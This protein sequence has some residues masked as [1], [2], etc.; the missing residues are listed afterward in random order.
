MSSRNLS[1]RYLAALALALTIG[2]AAPAFPQA[3]E[4]S[5]RPAAAV[6]RDQ[7]LQGAIDDTPAGRQ[8]LGTW[9]EQT[10]SGPKAVAAQAVALIRALRTAG[11]NDPGLLQQTA[12]R[13]AQSAEKILQQVHIYRASVAA[14]L[15]LGAGHIGFV[16]QSPDAVAPPGFEVILPRDAR[17]RGANMR[18]IRSPVAAPILQ[19]GIVGVRSVTLKVANGNYRL[20]LLTADMQVANLNR[21]P[22]GTTVRVNERS[23]TVAAATPREWLQKAVLGGGGGIGEGGALVLT[24]AVTDGTLIVSFLDPVGETFISGL[25]L[26]PL[27]QRSALNGVA[28]DGA[29]ENVATADA[30]IEDTVGSLLSEI[31]TAAGPQ[32]NNLGL[33][34]PPAPAPDSLSAN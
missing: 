23:Y 12:D 29:D 25:V 33:N 32:Q 6:T 28:N 1:H 24:A 34:N 11:I 3:P 5:D 4:R 31:A 16:F 9:L 13:I 30:A 18:A 19:A 8:A 15:A 10:G 2:V 17:L 14:N 26:E 7:A 27:G 20:I 22:F 21:A